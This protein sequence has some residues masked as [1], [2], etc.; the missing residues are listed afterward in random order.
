MNPSVRRS[1]AFL[2]VLLVAAATSFVPAARGEPLDDEFWED[3]EKEPE[4][5]GIWD[6]RT[7]NFGTGLTEC[8]QAGIPRDWPRPL[9]GRDKDMIER[10]SEGG[11]D[12]RV[13]LDYSCFAQDETSIA[14]NPLNPN[15]VVGGANDYRLGWGNSGFYATSDL[16][17]SWYGDI[18]PSPTPN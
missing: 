7:T 8:P 13:N 10:I 6:F 4:L 17:H 2:R 14:I 3:L 1:K 9:D 11:D 15:N 16:G 12:I 18:K 5:S